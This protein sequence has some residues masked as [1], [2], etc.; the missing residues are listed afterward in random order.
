M[1]P[2]RCERG[3][4]ER[5]SR[6]GGVLHP[7]MPHAPSYSPSSLLFP[8][9]HCPC[10]TSQHPPKHPNVLLT[11]G[12]SLENRDFGTDSHPHNWVKQMDSV[13]LLLLLSLLLF[14]VHIFPLSGQS[15]I[16]ESLTQ[17]RF[18]LAQQSLRSS[19]ILR[20]SCCCHYL[21]LLFLLN[22]DSWAHSLEMPI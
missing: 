8:P 16:G 1:E 20:H 11:T 15:G 21:C 7:T 6:G 22:M 14:L 2:S 9:Y 5:P 12:N 17:P 18:C 4:C 3:R 10:F 19:H 13:L